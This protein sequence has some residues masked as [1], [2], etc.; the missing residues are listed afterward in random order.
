MATS[1]LRSPRITILLAL[2]GILGLFIPL[3]LPLPIDSGS[4]RGYRVLT[5][6]PPDREGDVLRVLDRL[7]V[8][9]YASEAVCRLRPENPLTP[10]QPFIEEANALR[11]RWFTD[12]GIR[13]FYLP[14][15]QTR[16]RP[17]IKVLHELGF[18]VTLESGERSI[19]PIIPT[20]ALIMI[21]AF[22]LCGRSISFISSL[23]YAI[24]A[25]SIN[26]PL[27]AIASIF[28]ALSVLWYLDLMQGFP[29]RLT[30]RQSALRLRR[31]PFYL[32]PI[33]ASFLCV[34]PS[35]AHAL[36]LG[37]CALASSIAAFLLIHLF[38]DQRGS[39]PFRTRLH[40]RFAFVPI[41]AHSL[42]RANAA[43]RSFTAKSGGIAS[44]AMLAAIT[45][46]SLSPSQ[47]QQSAR[48]LSIPSPAR[49][50]GPVGFSL[51]SY[52]Q[53]VESR[54]VEEPSARLFDLAD[55]IDLRWREDS[56]PW[57]SIHASAR[58]PLPGQVITDTRFEV[59][60]TGAVRGRDRVVATF[61]DDYIRGVLRA[62]TTPLERMLE[63]QG[64]FVSCTRK[65][66][67]Q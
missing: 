1:S 10:H 23:P 59:D 2:V 60:Q 61:D 20:I 57:V 18:T 43:N 8:D 33:I 42:Y 51:E 62:R 55:F 39:L 40:P 48:E 47:P 28:G 41:S 27:G 44:I 7:G 29:D 31:N 11:A 12:G 14:S 32:A 5:V 3:A 4:W 67:G 50:T 65:R 25:Y 34:A 19:Q 30:P 52:R 26:T 15:G 56:F 64:R 22:V 17:L 24:I 38:S 16:E 6:S 9:G 66:Q 45:L 53:Y 21:I 49:Y 63:K 54:S 36:M 13:Y 35:G 46:H 37:L 58:D